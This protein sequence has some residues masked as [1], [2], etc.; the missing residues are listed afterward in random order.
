MVLLFE[1]SL[2][3]TRAL[4]APAPRAGAARRPV[5]AAGGATVSFYVAHSL[6]STPSFSAPLHL[7]RSPPLPAPAP[8][9]DAFNGDLRGLFE[10][11][12]HRGPQER[13]EE[14]ATRGDGSRSA[15][16]A[17]EARQA[18][19]RGRASAALGLAA[20]A[21]V[22]GRQDPP[23]TSGVASHAPWPRASGC[24]HSRRWPCCLPR[25]R[26]RASHKLPPHTC[27]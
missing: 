26:L 10:G 18:C 16:E 24:A 5:R 21:P 15:Y 8:A 23:C 11:T 19:T 20:A 13:S 9:L 12:G 27:V 6:S 17:V 14:C 3:Q 1:R 7:R 2:F 25:R 22:L 4:S